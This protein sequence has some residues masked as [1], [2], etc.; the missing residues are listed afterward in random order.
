M[1]NDLNRHFSKEDIQAVNKKDIKRCW[2]LL[3]IRETQIKTIVR[4]YLTPSR[5]ATIRN[6]QNTPQKQKITNDGEDTKKLEYCW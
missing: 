4:D 1:D 5:L 6:K 2:L 3:I